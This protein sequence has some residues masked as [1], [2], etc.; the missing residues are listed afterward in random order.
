MTDESSLTCGEYGCSV[1]I[2]I[3]TAQYLRFCRL[4]V[5]Y[6]CADGLW[7]VYAA[8]VSSEDSVHEFVAV[9]S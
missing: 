3:N 8:V 6:Y 4:R 5:Q 1:P 9:L 2:K 7:A